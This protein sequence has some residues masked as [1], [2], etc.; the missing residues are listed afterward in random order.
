MIQANLSASPADAV[1]IQAI[2]DRAVRDG[3]VKDRL[4]L[5]MDITAVHVNGCPLQLA[6]L[7][8]IETVH[9]LHDLSGIR[10]YV[11]RDTG[12]LTDGFVPRLAQ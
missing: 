5:M 6:R 7:L 9:F 11:D 3:H 2:V 1:L 4:G 12:K 10:A 8:E